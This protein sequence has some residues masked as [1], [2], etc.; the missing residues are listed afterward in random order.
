[1]VAAEVDII[2]KKNLAYRSPVTGAWIRT[3]AE[4]VEDLKR[5]G[6]VE[7]DEGVKQD[8]ERRIREDAERLSRDMA[9]TL[10]EEIARLPSVKRQRLY[11]ELTEQGL[12]LT[13]GRGTKG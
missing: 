4:R 9:S 5:T 1:M 11:S 7:Y 3:R 2:V 8:Y 12:D 10:E 6:C 13:V